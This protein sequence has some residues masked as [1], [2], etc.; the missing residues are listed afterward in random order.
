MANHWWSRKDREL[1]EEIQ[2][3]LAMAK[4]D[5]MERGESAES[6]ELAALRELG[7]RTL[8][9]EVTREMWGWS[10]LEGLWQDVRYA[11]RMMRRSPGFTAVAVLSLGLGIGANT[12]IFSLIHA[13]MLRPLPVE[14]PGRL[15]EP[16]TNFGDSKWNAF[17]WQAYEYMRDHNDVLSL[18]ADSPGY[19]HF[20]VHGDGFEWESVDGD[21]VSSNFFSVLEVKPAVGRLIDPT[22]TSPVAVLSWSYWQSR[23]HGDPGIV[24]KRIFVEGD[25]VTV[26]GVAAREFFGL[27]VGLKQD[28]WVPLAIDVVRP[29]SR[30]KLAS[31][32][33]L[34]LA[35]RLKPGVTM[36]QARAEMA[37]VFR[38]T[39]EEE[40]K[41]NDDLR[42]RAYTLD[43]E[44]AAAG[45][46]QLRSFY[47][48]PLLLLMTVV[49]LLL[50]IACMNVA[51]MLLARGAAREREMALRVSL[52]AGRFRLLRQMLTES[53]L[54][55]SIGSLLG[56]ALAYF[57]SNALVRLI[58]T[59]RQPVEL[60]IL[61]NAEVL[62]FTAGI[63]ILTG[64][65]FGLVPSLR[66]LGASPIAALRA[67][68]KSSETK[69]R[70]LFGKSLV[71]IQVALS[72][73]LLSA[74]GLFARHLSDL[75][76]IEL[77]FR[78]D[79]LVLMELDPAGS[80]YDG[81]RISRGY[82]QLLA[83]LDAIPGVRSAS[84]CGA[85]PIQGRSAGSPAKVEGYQDQA[86]ESR[87]IFQ[88]WVA[89][90]YFETLGSPLLAGRDFTFQDVDGPP[91]VIVNQAMARHYFGG[92]NPVGRH[93]VFDHND[94][95]YEIVGL[96]A[97]SKYAGI[98]QDMIPT[99][100]LHAFQRM[101]F[102]QFIIRTS[103]KPSAA[104]PEM[105]RVV[106]ESLKT[107]RVSSVTTMDEQIEASIV[108]E[109]L[110]AMLSELFGGLGSVLAAV[111]LYGLVA[112]TVARRK[113]EIGIRMALG[114]RRKDVIQ[115]VL[116][117]AM[118]MVCMGLAAGV[119]IV[120][121]SRRFAVNLIE[122][123]TVNT[124][125]PIV[126]GSMAMLAIALVAAYFPA[127][128]AA[129][130]DPMEALRHE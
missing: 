70:R 52:G 122:G 104:I 85:S 32:R 51:S 19:S 16:L 91:V 28:V 39:I 62:L 3:H 4:R 63:A 45:V 75:E 72:V 40:E 66:A 103:I 78:R 13:V 54:L 11:L 76:H 5:R 9:K 24:G 120:F 100:Y 116:R 112:Y 43:L 55:S 20:H 107:V 44:P 29:N 129:R 35:A 1:D 18:I 115:M 15:V 118:G 10:S 25:P 71:A 42:I 82:Q 31:N 125:V 33:Y 102:S 23:F 8:V 80:G 124:S 68:G 37:V 96:V 60:R 49:G 26:I 56:V 77:G 83:Q 101:P 126:F 14:E 65:L 92:G 87:M 128:R 113:N 98:Q 6:A 97:D 59:Q 47:A 99:A 89:P 38:R 121:W 94:R 41:I 79:H 110:V 57:G 93:V 105:R 36:E 64:V 53:L 130:V 119:P 50:L 34:T 46:S 109:R 67:A 12:A 61:P 58:S 81:E 7:N 108:P 127:R 2:A 88:N 48:K 106:R 114:A 86:G 21:Y 111:G 17:S 22:D 27:Q 123:L 30:A 69:G 74:A 90:R 73:V 95:Q 84:I 117:D